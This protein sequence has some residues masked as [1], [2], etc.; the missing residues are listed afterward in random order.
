[1]CNAFGSIAEFNASTW[2]GYLPVKDELVLAGKCNNNIIKIITATITRR[3]A[4]YI[5]AS[6]PTTTST[7]AE[8]GRARNGDGDGARVNDGVL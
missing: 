6:V 5:R 3:S 1:M 4:A 7:P 2:I 8:G